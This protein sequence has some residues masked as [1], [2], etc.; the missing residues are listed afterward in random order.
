MRNHNTQMSYYL[1]FPMGTHG[2]LTWVMTIVKDDTGNRNP[3]VMIRQLLADF[4]VIRKGF[5]PLTHSLEGC[6]SN[7]TELPNHPFFCVMFL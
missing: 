2:Y 3:Q 4:F 1:L 7:P 6:C 5:E